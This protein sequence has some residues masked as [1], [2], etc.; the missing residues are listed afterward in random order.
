MK[1]SFV[2]VEHSITAIGFRK[3]ASVA[4][5]IRPDIEVCYVVPMGVRS[6]FKLLFRREKIS[7]C[8]SDEDLKTIGKHLAKADMVCFSSLTPF[9][10]V[11]SKIIKAIRIANSKTYI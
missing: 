6:F 7:A 4:R 8:L 1:I 2:S 3:V 10:E 11:T 5:A 9:A